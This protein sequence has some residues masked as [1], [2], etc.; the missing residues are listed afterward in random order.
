MLPDAVPWLSHLRFGPALRHCKANHHAFSA[1]QDLDG[2]ISASSRVNFLI[3]DCDRSGGHAGELAD[4]PDDLARTDQS[5]TPT[6]PAAAI[7]TCSSQN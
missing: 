3:A 6:V 1:H 7:P 2:S 4:L 5:I